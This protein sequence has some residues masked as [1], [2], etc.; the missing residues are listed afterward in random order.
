[1][2]NKR[3][4]ALK[5]LIAQCFRCGLCR[6]V[7]P[8]FLR[9]G[10]E[11][12]VAR[13]K[14]QM[15]QALL[16]GDLEPSEHLAHLLSR[17]LVCGSCEQGCP[18]DVRVTEIILRARAQLVRALNLTRHESGPSIP[19]V[20]RWSR[21]LGAIRSRPE[22][23]LAVILDMLSGKGRCGR[24]VG[25]TKASVGIINKEAEPRN[26]LMR[27]AYFP[28]CG[29]SLYPQVT[30]ATLKVLREYRIAAVIP[31]GPVCC[32]APFLEAGDFSTAGRLARKNIKALQKYSPDA[33]VTTCALGART[34]KRYYRDLLALQ[35][36]S[37][38][39]Y[40]LEELLADA[41][42][43]PRKLMPVPLKACYVPSLGCGTGERRER[44]LL[45]EIP[46]L[47][48][49][50]PEVDAGSWGTSLFFPAIHP[51][52]FRKMI[53]RTVRDIAA[54][55]CDA[56]VTDSP[57][58]MILL[59]RALKDLRNPIRV[60]HTAEILAKA[61]GLEESSSVEMLSEESN[62]KKS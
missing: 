7:C 40:Q 23:P 43:R 45:D 14:L 51:D 33:L 12:A 46:K 17:C 47:E 31:E 61:L 24:P 27:V 57:F 44:N 2:V 36:F 54:C 26:A 50:R 20:A 56:V 6:A 53:R 25:L 62:G 21:Y 39:V 38:P 29:E 9:I 18:G 48:L 4:Q 37:F 52:L 5:D 60:M 41:G 3:P 35:P 28:G 13:G 16:N 11:P 8:V 58:S 49:I 22:Q 1:M 42:A 19:S 55:G 30:A 59:E 34:L 10:E 32:G 15:I